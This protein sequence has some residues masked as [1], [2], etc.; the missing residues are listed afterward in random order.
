MYYVPISTH[1][2]YVELPTFGENSAK[3]VW[4]STTMILTI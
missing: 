4:A 2:Y 3:T 1:T